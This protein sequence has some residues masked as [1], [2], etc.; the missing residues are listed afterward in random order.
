V[1]EQLGADPLSRGLLIGGTPY[2]VVG[3]LGERDVDIKGLE[4][5]GAQD[6][7]RVMLVPLSTVLNR[8]R[9]LELRSPLDEIQLQLRSEDVLHRAGTL[10]RRLLLAAHGGEEDFR[11]VIP[12]ELL[13]QKQQSQRLLDILTACVSS[14]SLIVG[15]IG[16]MNIMLAS[17]TERIREIGIRRAVGATQQDIK[18]QFLSEAVIISITGGVVGVAAALLTVVGTCRLLDL[19]VVVSMGMIVVAVVAAVL[20]GLIFG[21]YPAVQAAAK[22]PVE[23]L[24]YE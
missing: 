5:S 12:L 21:L 8:T 23:A 20:T 19:P 24:R 4:A 16:I 7:N 1:A 17:V 15:G 14:I 22:D 2:Q 9:E 11:L 13:K 3:V 6:W 18:L 10:I